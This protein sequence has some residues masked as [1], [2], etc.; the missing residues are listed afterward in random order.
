[1]GRPLNSVAR[2]IV[3]KRRGWDSNPRGRPRRPAVFKTAPFVRSGTPPEDMAA[4]RGQTRRRAGLA[5]A[6]RTARRTSGTSPPKFSR[7][8]STQRSGDRGAVQRVDEL[9]CRRSPGSGSRAGVGLVVGGVRRRRDLAVAPLRREPCLD[10][11]PLARGR[12][13]LPGGDVEHAVGETELLARALLRS[14]TQVELRPT[15][16][17]GGRTRTSRPC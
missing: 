13:Q 6:R 14:P 9:W 12:A 5:P 16:P 10:V 8:A 3:S 1:M 11:V 17:P 7:I 15:S 4:S 2:E